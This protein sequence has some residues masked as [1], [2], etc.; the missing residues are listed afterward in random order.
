MSDTKQFEGLSALAEATDG[1]ER[2]HNRPSVASV[3][4]SVGPYVA[5]ASVITFFAALLLRSNYDPAALV[6]LAVA[7][8][9]IPILAL[10]DRI[11]FDGVSLRRQGPASFL[12]RLFSGSGNKLKVDDFQTLSSQ[13][14]PTLRL[15]VS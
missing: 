9:V 6:F 12:L 1:Q 11:V 14:V 5:L 10:T 2:A 13:A 4:V 3:R 15:G 8:L 7:W